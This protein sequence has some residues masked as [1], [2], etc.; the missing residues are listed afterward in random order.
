LELE[1]C[2]FP[3]LKGIQLSNQFTKYSIEKFFILQQPHT[4][5]WAIYFII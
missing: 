1:D 3:L 5:L 2:A 4:E